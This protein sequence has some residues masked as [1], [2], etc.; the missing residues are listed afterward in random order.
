MEID[1]KSA[2]GLTGFKRFCDMSGSPNLVYITIMSQA[3]LRIFF[4]QNVQWLNGPFAMIYLY[5]FQ[6]MSPQES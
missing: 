5:K 6:S 4:S 1:E 2:F 3:V